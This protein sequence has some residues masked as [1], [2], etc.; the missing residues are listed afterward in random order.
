MFWP[1][2]RIRSPL[3]KPRE[4]ITTDYTSRG[5]LLP[6]FNSRR[7]YCKRYIYVY[8]TYTAWRCRK[9]NV[10]AGYDEDAR[11][12]EHGSAP[13]DKHWS[14]LHVGIELFPL[15]LP[16]AKR[17]MDYWL[18]RDYSAVVGTIARSIHLR[19][20]VF[21]AAK[22]ARRTV[23]ADLGL[24][25]PSAF[26]L[27]KSRRQRACFSKNFLIFFL[28]N[29]ASFI[30]DCASKYYLVNELW[31]IFFYLC[32]TSLYLRTQL[33]VVFR[34]QNIKRKSICDSCRSRKQKLR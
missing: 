2:L 25:R 7:K 1:F 23:L 17:I 13:T 33:T 8:N 10:C 12:L 9:K 11:K 6:R 16:P 5:V 26:F 14:Q 30:L 21:G 15:P 3:K 29:I 24:H 18:H 31:K 20:S 27:A 28:I 19:P 22:R 34:S 4:S 32:C